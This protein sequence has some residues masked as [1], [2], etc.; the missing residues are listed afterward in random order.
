MNTP[1]ELVRARPVARRYVRLLGAFLVLQALGGGAV[2]L[3][4][5]RGD[6]LPHAGLH[7]VSGMVA[8]WASSPRRAS[9]A[10]SRFAVGFGV[11]YLLLGALGQLDAPAVAALHLE[12]PD[13]VFHVV[14]GAATFSIGARRARVGPGRPEASPG[15]A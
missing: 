10:P 1:S 3:V 2:K 15:A 4:Q 9:C 12:A 7:L 14:V 11:L 13:Q 5:G 8:L 6:D